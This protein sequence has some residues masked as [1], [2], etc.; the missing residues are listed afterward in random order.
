MG[1][2]KDSIEGAIRFSFSIFNTIEDIDDTIS[3]L[4]EIIPKISFRNKR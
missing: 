1:L 3:A 2:S 4:E